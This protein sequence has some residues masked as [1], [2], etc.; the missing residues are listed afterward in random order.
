MRSLILIEVEHGETTDGINE[1]L[2]DLGVGS[3]LDPQTD[4]QWPTA[5]DGATWPRVEGGID[6]RVTDYAVMVDP[7]PRIT[8]ELEDLL[9]PL[10]WEERAKIEA[11]KPLDDGLLCT[12]CKYLG[13]GH[14]GDHIVP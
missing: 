2:F 3:S 14:D 8:P 12:L 6:Y 7:G 13:Q 1:A 9:A 5:S 11:G 10:M 4:S